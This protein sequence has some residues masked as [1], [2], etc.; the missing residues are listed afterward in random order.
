MQKR[1]ISVS[2]AIPTFKEIISLIKCTCTST[3]GADKGDNVIDKLAV[4]EVMTSK[5]YLLV[6][7]FEVV[8][9]MRFTVASENVGS[10]ESS[11]LETTFLGGSQVLGE[12]SVDSIYTRSDR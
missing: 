11:S 1:K 7:S 3:S 12:H 6:F 10:G 4:N 9:C 5:I 2:S 8:Q